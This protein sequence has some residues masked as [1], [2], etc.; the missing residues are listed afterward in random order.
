VGAV[1]IFGKFSSLGRTYL[2]QVLSSPVQTI[3][4]DAIVMDFSPQDVTED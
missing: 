1:T 2:G 3:K 4:K